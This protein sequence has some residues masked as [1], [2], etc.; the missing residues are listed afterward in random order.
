MDYCY[1]ESILKVVK[2]RIQKSP[3]KPY[4]KQKYYVPC[5]TIK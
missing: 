2:D 4:R 5:V 3:S 1:N